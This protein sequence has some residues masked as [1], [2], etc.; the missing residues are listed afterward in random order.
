M[1]VLLVRAGALGDV[2]LLR[3]AV[4]ALRSAG[5]RVRLLAPEV[6]GGVLVGHGPSEV[7]GLTPLDGPDVAR[8]LSG[9]ADSPSLID[10]F[11]AD[12]TLAL[13][14]STDLIETLRPFAG[15]LFS[16]SPHPKPG[17][18]ASIWLA[19]PVRALGAE[20]TP[21][22]EPL[23]FSPE[24]KEVARKAAPSLAPRFLAVHP[25][26]GSPSKSWPGERFASFVRHHEPA[27]PW[28]LVIGPADEEAA[29]PLLGLPGVVPVRDLPLR[30]LG[31]LLSQAGLYLGNDSGVTHLAAAVGAPT[32]ALFGPT[33]PS[34]W[35][36]LGP[37]V[38]VLR[39]PDATMTGLTLAVVATAARELHHS[40]EQAVDSLRAL[41]RAR[42][43]C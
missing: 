19:G 24:E 32:L 11:R 34:T 7:A 27:A 25:G 26:S 35:S 13:T 31:A 14:D 40:S 3:R 5:H 28:V 30:P 10:G 38:K 41:A 12:A 36:P 33:D 1:E 4:F 39:S 37:H 21:E 20:P 2:L 18:H 23:V 9:E 6:P 17:H 8:L 22:P 29:S 16:R 42:L 15:R 43:R